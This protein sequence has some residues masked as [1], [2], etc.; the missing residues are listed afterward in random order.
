M[1]RLTIP[2]L[3][4]ASLLL[5]GAIVGCSSSQAKLETMAKI[6]KAEAA[7]IALTKAP[8]GTVK[9]AELEKENGKLV[10]SFDIA[11][12]GSKDITEVQVDAVSGVVVSVESESPAAQAKEAREDREGKK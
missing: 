5:A 12:A 2:L 4:V 10:W 3:L 6:S 7:R 1:K 8:G 11:T 9:E